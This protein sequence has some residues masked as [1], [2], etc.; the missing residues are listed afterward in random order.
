MGKKSLYQLTKESNAKLGRS[1][2]LQKN[3][4]RIAK[5]SLDAQKEQINI[6]KALLEK[7]EA[8][9]KEAEYQKGIKGLI[10]DLKNRVEDHS[11]NPT[12]EAIYSIYAQRY[13][14]KVGLT[15]NSFVE[16]SDKEYFQNFLKLIKSLGEKLTDNQKSI[17][18]SYFDYRFKLDD[19]QQL[20][21][22]LIKHRKENEFFLSILK[23][24]S[25]LPPLILIRP[26]LITWQKSMIYSQ[27]RAIATLSSPNPFLTPEKFPFLGLYPE[28]KQYKKSS[29]LEEYI[30]KEK[31]ALEKSLENKVFEFP[32]LSN[33]E[34]K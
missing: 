8:S 10:F 11:S 34:P 19:L 15:A 33:L 18:N 4:E 20:E 22:D 7:A 5:D 14:D 29:E 6:S 17:I 2:E 28:I 13:I 25:W 9:Q 24:L 31:M 16:I 30:K 12:L 26:I 1:L 21:Y 32:E 3:A 27:F 23:L